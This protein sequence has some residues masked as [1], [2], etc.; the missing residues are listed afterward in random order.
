[1]SEPRVYGLMAEFE[2]PTDIVVAATRAHDAG[3]ES[4]VQGC[5]FQAVVAHGRRGF[6]QREDLGVGR[7]IVSRDRRVAAAA[8]DN[9]ARPQ[10][11]E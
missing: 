3:F 11:A 5:R 4:T 1:M 7:R 10:A 6:T 8:D 2:T 9:A